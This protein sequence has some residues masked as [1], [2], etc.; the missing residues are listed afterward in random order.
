MG[1]R[2]FGT[3]FAKPAYVLT[4]SLIAW[5]VFTVAVLLPNI[6]LIGVVVFSNTASVVEK[7][8]FF[9][10]L[11]GSIGTNFTPL[12]ALST[13]AIAILFGINLTLLVYYLRRVRGAAGGVTATNVAG[14]GGL[15]SGMLGI[16]CAACGTFVLTSVLALIGAGSIVAYLPFGGE[17]FGFIGIGLLLHSIAL[18]LKKIERPLV[19]DSN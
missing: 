10:S 14:I 6:Q 3:V 2:Q 18:L 16:G 1:Q 19:C 7:I 9:L 12:S 13:I 15:V 5:M 17:E 11:Y 8:N 4:A